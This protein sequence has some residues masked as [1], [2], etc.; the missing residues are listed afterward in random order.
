[1][2]ES[3]L[4]TLSRFLPGGHVLRIS[5]AVSSLEVE[6]EYLSIMEYLN[7]IQENITM[8]LKKY[9][10]QSLSLLRQMAEKRYVIVKRPSDPVVKMIVRSNIGGIITQTTS[11]TVGLSE[12]IWTDQLAPF[13]NDS[14][15]LG[16]CQQSDCHHHRLTGGRKEA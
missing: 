2:A 5:G 11:T 8:V 10:R 6:K 15:N 14:N 7:P 12:D 16:K 4:F 1:M 3:E 9:P 13:C